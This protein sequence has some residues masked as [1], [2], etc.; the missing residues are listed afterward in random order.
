ML[1]DKGIVRTIWESPRWEEI[2]K[3]HL[4]FF[5]DPLPHHEPTLCQVA[6]PGDTRVEDLGPV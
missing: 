5:K 1:E 2:K 4:E 6:V 3:E